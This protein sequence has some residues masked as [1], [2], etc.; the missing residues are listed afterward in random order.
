[1]RRVAPLALAL[2]ALG[3]AG[4]GGEEDARPLPEGVEGTSSA[5]TQTGATTTTAEPAAGDPAAGKAVFN[6]QGC[7]SCHAY[8]PAGSGGQVGPNLDNLEQDAE[9]AG[10]GSLEEYTKESITDPDAYVVSGFNEGIMPPYDLPEKQLNDL[11][12]FL[13]QGQ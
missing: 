6:E 9:E 7:G 11:V 5:Q 10:R 3:L 8:G 2:L 12:A 13:T 4:C 1:M